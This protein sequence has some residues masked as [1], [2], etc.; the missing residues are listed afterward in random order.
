MISG[1]FRASFV[2]EVSQNFLL[3]H[4]FVVLKGQIQQRPKLCS[5]ILN[6][7]QTPKVKILVV[8]EPAV[9]V[10]TQHFFNHLT[11]MAKLVQI[12]HRIEHGLAT[13]INLFLKQLCILFTQVF[14]LSVEQSHVESQ[15]FLFIGVADF[16]K[17]VEFKHQFPHFLKRMVFST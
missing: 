16:E 8:G 17:T 4:Y 11:N 7:I 3:S 2:L 5:L 15:L 1:K 9:A 13:S 14:D 6:G 12:W 10:L